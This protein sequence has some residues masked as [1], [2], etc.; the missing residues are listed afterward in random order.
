MDLRTN[1]AYFIVVAVLSVKIWRD[2]A[3]NSGLSLMRS[4]QRTFE[5][6]Q[7]STANALSSS[8]TVQ[9]IPEITFLEIVSNVT[10][11]MKGVESRK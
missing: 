3:E 6:L 11:G 10:N 2:L 8:I 7:Y 9:N 5:S 1:A 4:N